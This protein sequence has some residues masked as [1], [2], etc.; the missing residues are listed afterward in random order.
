MNWIESVNILDRESTASKNTAR[1]TAASINPPSGPLNTLCGAGDKQAP[2][3]HNIPFPL[4]G[5]LANATF[6][7]SIP[8]PWILALTPSVL[9]KIKATRVSCR[10]NIVIARKRIK[11]GIHQAETEMRPIEYNISHL[12][13]IPGIYLF[14]GCSVHIMII[15]SWECDRHVLEVLISSGWF[16]ADVWL[17]VLS[18][19][20]NCDWLFDLSVLL[21]LVALLLT[22]GCIVW[23]H[24]DAC[25]GGGERTGIVA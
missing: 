6:L 12:Y 22:D 18:M 8:P 25:S 9:C 14:P 23:L 2:E 20:G 17:F 1:N 19:A 24:Y 16:V 3:R 4:L 7:P 5:F 13:L 15:L 21:R 11:Q 10:A